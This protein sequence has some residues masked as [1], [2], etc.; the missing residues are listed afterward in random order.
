MIDATK[1]TNKMQEA[2]DEPSDDMSKGAKMIVMRYKTI[3]KTNKW[4]KQNVRW[5]EQDEQ[6]EQDS[7][8]NQK[9]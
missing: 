9:Q 7:K 1:V 6:N 2:T 8:C 4:N 5:N 3:D